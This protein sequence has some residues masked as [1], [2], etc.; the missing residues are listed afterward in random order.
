M[1]APYPSQQPPRK[2]TRSTSNKLIGGVCGGVA[3]YLNMDVTLVRILTVVITLFTGPVPIVLYLVAL[4]LLPEDRAVAP[5][6]SVNGPQPYPGAGAWQSEPTYAPYPSAAP[7]PG[8]PPPAGQAPEEAAVWGPD[9]PPWQQRPA[10]DASSTG[11]ATAIP[12]QHPTQE[13]EPEPVAETST[14]EA[15]QGEESTWE[16]SAAEPSDASSQPSGETPPPSG[17]DRADDQPKP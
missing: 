12:E 5:P 6:A 9:G 16:S 15:P 7:G 11:P 17:H 2:L 13:P 3:A 8:A 4:F 14:P 1:A 10:A